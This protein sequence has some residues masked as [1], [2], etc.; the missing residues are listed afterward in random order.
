MLVKLGI[1]FENTAQ[2]WWDEGGRDLWT[3]LA[4]EADAS[5]TVVD[6]SIAKS[7]L[8][9][10]QAIPGWY[11]GPEYAPHPICMSQLDPDEIV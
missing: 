4:E 7:W 9:Q 11:D 6:E 3:S 1:D 2:G 8:E 5:S 10:A